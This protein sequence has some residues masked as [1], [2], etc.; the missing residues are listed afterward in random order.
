MSWVER[1][2]SQG[3]GLVCAAGRVCGP[4]GVQ[5]GRHTGH[6]ASSQAR[7]H[8]LGGEADGLAAR[9]ASG[10]ASTIGLMPGHGAG[11]AGPEA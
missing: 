9:G 2:L 7:V 5:D 4:Q 6:S 1:Q 11:A 8:G 10:M 3:G